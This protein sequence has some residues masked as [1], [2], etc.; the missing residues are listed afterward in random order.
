MGA[1]KFGSI[2]QGIVFVCVK[3]S[4]PSVL[5]IFQNEAKGQIHFCCTFQIVEKTIK[6]LIHDCF[7]ESLNCVIEHFVSRPFKFRIHQEMLTRTQ[8]LSICDPQ[9]LP[10][11]VPHPHLLFLIRSA[12]RVACFYVDVKRKILETLESKVYTWRWHQVLGRC[13]S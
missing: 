11:Y 4:E 8:L 12:F 6:F 9:H 13:A 10:L 7:V 1:H 3:I 2:Q 5:Y